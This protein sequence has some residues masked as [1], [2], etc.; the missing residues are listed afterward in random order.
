MHIRI[1]LAHVTSG[2][3]AMLA[4]VSDSVEC[5]LLY[6]VTVVL[7]LILVHMISLFI[8]FEVHLRWP[9]DAQFS[10]V[11]AAFSYPHQ[12]N[13]SKEGSHRLPKHLIFVNCF[14]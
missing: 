2:E 11:S 4:I 9:K 10:G 8:L 1:L 5:P 12:M 14:G 13:H 7:T 3:S 6:C